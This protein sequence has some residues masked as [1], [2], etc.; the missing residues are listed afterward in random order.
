[1]ASRQEMRVPADL[2]RHAQR[3]AVRLAAGPVVGGMKH[4]EGVLLDEIALELICG[5]PLNLVD[6]VLVREERGFVR[7]DHVPPGGR[8]PLQHVERGHHRRRDPVDARIRRAADDV[9]NGLRH[10]RDADVAFEAI[11]DLDGGERRCPSGR[12]ERRRQRTEV[13]PRRRS[14]RRKPCSG[15]EKRAAGDLH[16]ADCATRAAAGGIF[17]RRHYDGIDMTTS[18]RR[19]TWVA[20]TIFIFTWSLTTHG[21]YS[22]SGDEPHYLMITHSLLVDGD[23]DVANNYDSNDGRFFGHAGL[24]RG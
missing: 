23:L 21:K 4:D 7:D 6:L 10:P 9:V 1:L 17:S 22:V 3:D 24:D 18:A 11:E 14:S 15:C 2:A 19:R 12:R 16:G 20:A 13:P 8:S 5:A